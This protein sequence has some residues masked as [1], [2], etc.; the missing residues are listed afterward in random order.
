MTMLL[1][2]HGDSLAVPSAA[3][4]Q[5]LGVCCQPVCIVTCFL[6]ALLIPF[7]SFIYVWLS[8]VSLSSGEIESQ[9]VMCQ[10]S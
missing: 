9:P 4:M 1:A 10:Q 7:V 6:F 8:P 2:A 3:A 5:V